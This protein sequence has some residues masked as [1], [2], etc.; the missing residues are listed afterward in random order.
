MTLALATYTDLITTLPSYAARDDLTTF[1]PLSVKLFEAK[2]NRSLQCKDMETRATTAVDTASSE[3]EFVSLPSNYQTMR[4]VRIS[5]VSGKPRLVF[6]PNAMIDEK[7]FVAQNTT[8]QPIYF[9]VIGS[10][11]ELFPTP[12][13]AYTIE[14]TYRT[15]IPNLQDNSSNWL[16]TSHPDAYLYGCLLEAEPYMKND[17]RLQTWG[18]LLSQ[19]IADINKIGMDEAFNAGPLQMMVSGSPTP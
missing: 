6:L 4:R 2:M 14:M 18:T 12:D 11:M 15:L 8:G 1:W 5:S 7:R 3:P 9:T 10:E 17:A 13:S 16:L 19:V